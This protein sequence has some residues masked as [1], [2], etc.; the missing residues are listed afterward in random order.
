MARAGT[1]TQP[2]T[3]VIC[4]PRGSRI[5]RLVP[6]L[7]V[8]ALVGALVVATPPRTV[9]AAGEGNGSSTEDSIEAQVRYDSDARDDPGCSW[10][11]VTGVD[12]VSGTTRELPTTR[13]VKGR[14]WTLYE[15]A[16]GTRRSLHWVR[17]DTTDTMAASSQ[18]RVRRLVPT[19]L[20]NTAPAADR[21]VV[22]VGSWFWVPAQLWRPVSVTAMIPTTAGPIIVTTTAVPTLLIYSPGDGG[23]PVTC[24]GPGLPW[25]RVFGDRA[26]SPCMHTY[27]RA[28][29]TRPS[30][31]YAAR[32]SVQWTVTWTS[33]L[34]VGGGLPPIRLG[35]GTKVRVV[36]LQA[37]SR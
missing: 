22:N 34:G 12:P 28:S 14:S 26:V 8:A 5:V 36:E 30:G 7:L 2:T 11:P 21:M 27:T 20:V 1:P 33:N 6:T 13:V 23:T 3:D 9:L 15:R 37:L 4:D 17:S 19:L 10:S 31:R 24:R 16:C 25:R 29:H 18:S 32:L 35:I